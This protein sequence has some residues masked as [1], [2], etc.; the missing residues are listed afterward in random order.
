VELADALAHR[1][2]IEV[3][4]FTSMYPNWLYPQGAVPVDATL[5]PREHPRLSVRRCLAWYNPLGWIGSAWRVVAEVLH[6][7]F[8]SLPLAPVWATMMLVA[9]WRG[10][11]T[12]VTLHNLAGH[13]RR[14][15]FRLASRVLVGLAD[16]VIT[17]TSQLP[18]WLI[19]AT[20]RKSRAVIPHGVLH[21]DVAEAPAPIPP[22]PVGSKVILFFGSIR[23]YKG[24]DDLLL[25]F[26]KVQERVPEARLVIAGRLW[27]PS[28]DRYEELISDA[29]TRAKV[30][31]HI[32]FVPTA[33]VPA[34]M[35]M[36]D[37]VVLP[38]RK[39]D[40]QSGVAASAIAW[41]R[42]IVVTDVGGLP[43]LQ[44]DKNYVVRAGDV[45][46]LASAII[47]ALATPGELER[48]S[49]LSREVRASLSWG[50]IAEQTVELYRRVLG[51]AGTS[52]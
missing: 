52:S 46:A 41:D 18:D 38:Y 50:P 17:H 2:S 9:R 39:F 20:R 21:A 13:E 40:S 24:L 31:K 10:I 30:I 22:L 42:P 27:E 11:K 45:D 43:A 26:G 25:A 19:H 28:W 48:L 8:W 3:L 16:V 15:A 51:R 34:L 12:V 14:G 47:R 44:L 29:T 32:A 6:I 1:T 33:Q 7:Q 35:Q 4:T 23:P 37:L 5:A 49:T 36:S